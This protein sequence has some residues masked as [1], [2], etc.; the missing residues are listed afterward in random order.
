MTRNVITFFL[1]TRQSAANIML[2]VL[3]I[4]TPITQTGAN[5]F[6]Q[7]SWINTVTDCFPRWLFRK[8]DNN[9]SPKYLLQ[10]LNFP[11][12]TFDASLKIEACTHQPESESMVILKD[13][14]QSIPRVLNPESLPPTSS[15]ALRYRVHQDLK[16]LHKALKN[17]G[18]FE[19]E[20]DYEWTRIDKNTDCNNGIKK[21][22][23]I[24]LKVKT[25]PR[26][27]FGTSNIEIEGLENDPTKHH[28][29]T[30]KSIKIIATPPGSPVEL[31]DVV[32]SLLR[33]KKY[34]Q[35]IGYPLVDIT[36]PLGKIDEAT[37]TL[38][39][40]YKIILGGKKKFG[41]IQIIGLTNLS[42]SYV[43][44]RL[45]FAPGETYDQR[46]LETSQQNLLDSELFSSLT[47]TPSPSHQDST[48]PLTLQLLEGPPRSVGAGIR[49]AT[50]EGIGGKLYWQ[51]RNF[52]GGGERVLAKIE[53]SQKE[54]DA[55]LSFEKPDFYWKDF[56]LVTK[57]DGRKAH[58]KA[59]HGEIYSIYGGIRHRWNRQL[60][61]DVGTHY[62]YSRLKQNDFITRS[63]TALPV[64]ILYDTS[65][66]PINPFRGWKIKFYGAPFFGDI[67]ENKFM[68]KTSLFGSYYAR[69]IKKDILV[70]ALW[71]RVGRILATP[72]TGVPLDK[73]FYSGGINSVRGYGF[74][75]LGP[76]SH[77][78]KPT[79]GRSQ[80]EMGIEP[81]IRIGEKFGFSVFVEGGKVSATGLPKDLLSQD[82][83]L[84]KQNRFMVGYGVGAKYYTDIGPITLDLAFPTKRR[85]IP[86]RKGVPKKYDDA[87]Q[88][89]LS[90]GQSF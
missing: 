76:I 28:H 87:F 56:T 30:E 44:N 60:I 5:D 24:I 73:R 68:A 52:A 74:Q 16:L 25:G 67:G 6:H 15:H 71:G 88:V 31:D 79:G 62:E 54:I 20:I 65:N 29:F 42:E 50:Q 83:K 78:G 90:I 53:G 81:R 49:Y 89:Y 13:Y 17:K 86:G 35:G 66:D 18:F 45:T 9:Y 80:I 69:L 32:D 21:E 11:E 57:I 10:D 70:I 33:L 8:D 40:N 48:V 26:Y 85:S 41:D 58:T 1:S 84:G 22:I 63:F 51:H 23:N 82:P 34:F 46:K 38:T 59:Y 72:L 7:K 27:V 37:K 36:P 55:I 47:L 4:F 43:L 3:L 14:L 19:G 77:D 64:N 75:R 61:Y 2:L 39:V 12:V